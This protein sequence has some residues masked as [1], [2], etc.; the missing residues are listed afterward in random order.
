MK[1]FN[2]TCIF[3]L[4]YVYSFHST[5][6]LFLSMINNSKVFLF[7]PFHFKMLLLFFH[8]VIVFAE[9]KSVIHNYKMIYLIIYFYSN[10]LS[11]LFICCIFF[12]FIRYY[13]LFSIFPYIIYSIL[14]KSNKI[15]LLFIDLSTFF[16]AHK[17][18]IKKKS[19]R[20]DM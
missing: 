8:Q 18:R 19:K 20:Y 9:N 10:Y 2:L 11:I 15:T 4:F 16:F 3:I 6:Y 12:K 7:S 13:F 17:K 14:V 1:R 5:F